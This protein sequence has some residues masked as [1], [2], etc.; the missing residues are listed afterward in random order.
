[1]SIKAL[2]ENRL[3]VNSLK[4]LEWCEFAKLERLTIIQHSIVMIIMPHVIMV[5]YAKKI[6]MFTMY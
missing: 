3:Q 4:I 2:I 6:H 1:M 5:E